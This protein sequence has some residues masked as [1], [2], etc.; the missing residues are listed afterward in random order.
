MSNALNSTMAVVKQIS[1]QA[2]TWGSDIISLFISGMMSRMNDLANAADNV[3]EVIRARLHFST[4]DTGP[5]ADAGSYMPDMIALLVK[6]M[7]SGK[8]LVGAAAHGLAGEMAGNII[9]AI[10]ALGRAAKPQA[11]TV[12]T[13]TNTNSSRN[14]VLHSNIQNTFNGE[15]AAQQ[16]AARIMRQS[17]ED[18]TAI[19]ARGIAY[20]R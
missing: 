9:G 6:G 5:L 18:V 7:A 8:G 20:A 13:V 17:G 11:A 14:V 10:S 12:S 3:A 15:K 16:N 19:L 4:P 2:R 1:A